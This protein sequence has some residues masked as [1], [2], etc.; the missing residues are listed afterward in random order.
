MAM[1]RWRPIVGGLCL[2]LAFGSLYAWSVFVLP[3]EHEFGWT[4]AQTSWVYTIA[5][6][7]TVLAT[8]IGGRLQDRRG[9]LI[10][11][12]VG[13]GLMASG[14]FLCSLVGSLPQLYAA[15]AIGAFGAGCGYAAPMPVASK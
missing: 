11:V 7:V 14:Y 2:N 1:N 5:I 9:P 10:S 13:G 4:R 6:I 8:L 3:L 12:L 15:Y